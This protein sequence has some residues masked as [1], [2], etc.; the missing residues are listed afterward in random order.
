MPNHDKARI[1]ECV[2]RDPGFSPFE[3]AELGLETNTE[4]LDPS[5]P[6]SVIVVPEQDPRSSR[7]RS[8]RF[9]FSRSNRYKRDARAVVVVVE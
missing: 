7:I 4:V 9:P 1:S 2:V 3:R 5:K 8:R 6:L